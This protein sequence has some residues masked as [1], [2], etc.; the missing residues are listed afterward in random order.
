MPRRA[1]LTAF[2]LG[3]FA[4]AMVCRPTPAED[5]PAGP[6][7]QPPQDRA[8]GGGPPPEGGQGPRGRAGPAPGYHLLP[9]FAMRQLDLSDDQ[10]QQ[11]ATLEKETREKLNKILTADQQKKLDELR[12]P[13][14][15]GGPPARGGPPGAQG[16]GGADTDAPPGYRPPDPQ[17]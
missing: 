4:A 10:K 2:C 9:R 8:A 7:Q 1:Y 17:R 12:P 13:P 16:G 15:P 3:L 6:Y 11:L 5:Q 14:P